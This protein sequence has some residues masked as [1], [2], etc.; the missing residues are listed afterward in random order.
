MDIQK[1]TAEAKKKFCGGAQ[2]RFKM[3]EN[4]VAV[5]YCAFTTRNPTGQEIKTPVGNTKRKH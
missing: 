2:N 3:R 1:N 4:T 5:E